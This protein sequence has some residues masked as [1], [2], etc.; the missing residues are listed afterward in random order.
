MQKKTKIIARAIIK[1]V[2]KWLNSFIV[3]DGVSKTLSPRK[4]ILGKDMKFNRHCQLEIGSCVQGN[5]CLDPSS[6][7]EY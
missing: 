6:R 7:P 4:I 1:H 2:T 5:E 3:N